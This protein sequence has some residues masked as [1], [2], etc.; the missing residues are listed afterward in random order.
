MLYK[1]GQIPCILWPNPNISGKLCQHFPSIPTLVVITWLPHPNL[2][3]HHIPFL[4]VGTYFTSMWKYYF[5][6]CLV[7]LSA[8]FLHV[9]QLLTLSVRLPAALQVSEMFIFH[10]ST[11]F[12]CGLLWK[13]GVEKEREHVLTG[14]YSSFVSS[15]RKNFLSLYKFCGRL[16]EASCSLVLKWCSMQLSKK[17][18]VYCRNWNYL[19]FDHLQLQA[20]FFSPCVR[21]CQR[22]MGLIQ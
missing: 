20:T 13:L 16:M 3:Y 7:L 12:C 19:M 21:H 15:F 14:E 8:S 6:S 5:F 1:N 9:A 10:I 17:E 22:N 2:F 4:S 18:L 11:T